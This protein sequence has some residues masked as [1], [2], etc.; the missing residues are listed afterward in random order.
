MPDWGDIGLL[1]LGL[2][3]L[4]AA[5]PLAGALVQLRA[6]ARAWAQVAA[7]VQEVLPAF[8]ESARQVGEAAAGVR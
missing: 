1:A 7:G 2:A 6:A 3:A 4:V 8:G 5:V